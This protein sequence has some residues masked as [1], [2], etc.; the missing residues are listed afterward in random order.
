MRIKAILTLSLISL[1]LFSCSTEKKFDFNQQWTWQDLRDFTENEDT[2]RMINNIKKLVPLEDARYLFREIAK[3]EQPKDVYK[4]TRIERKQ[5]ESGGGFF[6]VLPNHFD[7]QNLIPLPIDF[8]KTIRLGLY[9]SKVRKNNVRD[10]LT[11]NIGYNLT[12]DNKEL[13]K[14]EVPGPDNISLRLNF[15]QLDNILTYYDNMESS[16]LKELATEDIF[17]SMIDARRENKTIDAPY[18]VRTDYIYFIGAAAMDSPERKIWNWINPANNFG[19]SEFYTNRQLYADFIDYLREN[20]RDFITPITHRLSQYLPQE[21]RYDGELQFS[22]NFGQNLWPTP[23]GVGFNI[24]QLK[25]NYSNY[26]IGARKEIFKQLHTQLCIKPADKKQNFQYD[27][28]SYWNFEREEDRKFYSILAFTYMEGLATYISGRPKGFDFFLQVKE[29]V[30]Y[31]EQIHNVIYNT[32]K[33]RLLTQLENFGT[34][35]YGPLT[36][37]GYLMA[38]TIETY[39]GKDEI[40]RCIENGPVYFFNKFYDHRKTIKNRSFVHITEEVADRIEGLYKR[41]KKHYR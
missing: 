15:S 6:G 1:L 24:V 30:S 41:Q 32:K 38:R 29:S 34:E 13:N 12:F 23:T 5:H 28:I 40:I 11:A 3:F 22:V 36:G 2:H 19:F 4:L 10:L 27:D 31:L 37:L 20:N 39:F 17:T 21:V 35:P 25:D 7:Q 9:L 33:E 26:F 16:K 14:S 18:P 8:N